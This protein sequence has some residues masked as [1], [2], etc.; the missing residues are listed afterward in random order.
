MVMT[1]KEDLHNS[2]KAVEHMLDTELNSSKK[3]QSHWWLENVIISFYAKS[4]S[5]SDIEK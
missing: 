5:V 1:S 3:A 4:I 2:S